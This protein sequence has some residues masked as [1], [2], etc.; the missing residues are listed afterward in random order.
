MTLCRII[1]AYHVPRQTNPQTL[2]NDGPSFL[3]DIPV[4]AGGRPRLMPRT[5]PQR[6]RPEPIEP[7]TKVELMSL[8]R[9]M[10]SQ[11]PDILETRPSLTEGRTADGLYVRKNYDKVNPIVAANRALKY[12]IGHA[13]PTESSLHIFLSEADARKI[14][15]ARWGQ[16]FCLPH[17]HLR[18]WTMIYAPRNEAEL[19]LVEEFVKASVRWATEVSI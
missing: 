13:H 5:L 16:R 15:E 3:K 14:I 4:R 8:M 11:R 9:R 10:A 17:A 2:S 19:A 1:F 18:G 12:E 6:Q 7:S